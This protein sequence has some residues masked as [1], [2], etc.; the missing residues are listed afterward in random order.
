MDNDR[1]SDTVSDGAVVC[2]G[3]LSYLQLMVVDHVP[4]HNGGTPIS[5]L[6]DSFGDDAGIVA[7]MLYQWGQ[8]ARF[9]PSAVGADDLGG[10][11]TQTVKHLGVPAELEVNP[12]VSTVAELSIADPSGARTYFYKRTPELLAT[13]DSADLTPLASASYLYVD[14][15]DGDHILRPMQAASGLGIQVFVNL[16][17]QHDNDELLLKLLPYSTVCQVSVDGTSAKEDMESVAK[18][19]LETGIGTVIVTGGS[20]GSVVANARQRV[21]VLAPVV[22]V[23]DGNGAGSCFS[24]GFIYGSL[25]GWDLEQC[26]R[27]ATAQAS[28]KCGVSGYKVSS[29]EAGKCLA[30]TLLSEVRTEV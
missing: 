12:D 5:Q 22:D 15:Y 24:A 11:V 4:V 6:T 20:R 30:S 10:R 3:V 19:L 9:I 29:I 7:W 1:T 2:F 23:T 17:D 25:R 21:M 27:F 13:L 16:E 18:K 14:W 8:R 28:L 26:A